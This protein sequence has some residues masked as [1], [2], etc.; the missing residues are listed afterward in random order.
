MRQLKYKEP[1]KHSGELRTQVAFFG[2]KPNEGP[3]PGES[4]DID[5][6]KCWAAVDQVWL[7]DLEQ[8]KANGTLSD[9]T[10]TIRDPGADY[11]PTDKHY[12]KVF[13][14]EFEHLKYNIR[15]AQPNLK[16][17]RF[18]DIVAEVSTR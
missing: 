5:L 2:A 16:D 17:R 15:T 9:L 10:I 12:V 4:K 18:I 11:R 6:Y 3:M 13:E 1:R 8:A 14:P 7:R